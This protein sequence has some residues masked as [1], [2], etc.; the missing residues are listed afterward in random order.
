MVFFEIGGASKYSSSSSSSEE[1]EEDITLLADF[2][3]KLLLLLLLSDSTIDAVE[4]VG[5]VVEEEFAGEDL[6]LA[7]LFFRFLESL[8]AFDL[9]DAS[10][11][12]DEELGVVGGLFF[13]LPFVTTLQSPSDIR[14]F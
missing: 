11:E 12:E 4:G 7:R 9:E 6:F 5:D 2:L 13:L 10:L 1:E 3:L 14:S 8:E